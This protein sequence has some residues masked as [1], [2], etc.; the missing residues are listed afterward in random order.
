M[1]GA[2]LRW[3]VPFRSFF[4]MSKWVFPK[5]GVPQNGWVIMENPI[6]MDDLGG[7]SN[8]YFRKD[9]KNCSRFQKFQKFSENN[10]PPQVVQTRRPRHWDS[11]EPQIPSQVAVP[12]DWLGSFEAWSW[13]IYIKIWG[14]YEVYQLSDIV[15][16]SMQLH[17]FLTRECYS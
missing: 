3:R 7:K 6:K 14:R 12:R 9:P 10:A 15:V 1:L 5:I 13:K 17:T 16:I 8:H 2:S 11:W 4:N